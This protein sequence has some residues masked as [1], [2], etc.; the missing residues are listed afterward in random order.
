VG[1]VRSLARKVDA[2]AVPP[3]DLPARGELS[4]PRAGV[5]ETSLAWVVPLLAVL[6]VLC[7]GAGMGWSF[8]APPLDSAEQLVWSY[9]LELGY[10]KHPPLPSWIMHGLVA[11]FGPSVPLPFFAAHACTAIALLLAWRLGCEFMSPL[12]SLCAAA[13]TALVGCHGWAN[14]EFNHNSVLLPFQAATLLCFWFAVTRERWSLWWW[15]LAGVFAGLALLVK[16]VALL[17]L[18]A[19]GLYFLTQRRLHV[20]RHILGALLA[21]GTAMAV[22]A[23]HL[24][25]LAS[26]QYMPLLYARRVT[27]HASDFVAWLRAM[28][29]FLLAQAG[30]LSFFMLSAVS[31]WKFRLPPSDPAI[32][33]RP[34]EARRFVW[35]SGAVPAALLLGYAALTGAV[36]EPRWGS[37]LYLLSG[38]LL[39]DLL[40]PSEA[41]TRRVLR[42]A[43]MVQ[44]G[45]W[46]AV[47]LAV[48]VLASALHWQS[49]PQFPGDEL[50]RLATGT[51]SRATDA[52]LRLVV[53]DVWLGGTLVAYSGRPLAV[54]IDG[55]FDRAAWVAPR[56]LLDCGALVL[57]DRSVPR[58]QWRAQV[59]RAIE[60]A[61][62]RGEWL[63]PWS[64][65]RGLRHRDASP[66]R[67]IAW[68][69]L[70][71]KDAANCR[72]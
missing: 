25:W 65:S 55:E 31:L 71:P 44:A 7:W 6:F 36:L 50:A 30:Q 46:A 70:P 61:P 22:V 19:M 57:Q 37:N 53:S 49:R 5:A 9:A 1:N 23:P 67:R 59:T 39:L 34:V 26:H 43:A 17:P 58:V 8:R 52:R 62:L 56:D 41:G 33:R 16:Y 11:V 32:V 24:A 45:L 48:P 4:S 54:L 66:R 72:L 38:W 29:I 14:Y 2:A 28:G 47:A 27:L 21:C 40:A 51:W 12:R 60:G 18:G 13:L 20:G 64:P 3:R 10:W 69:V 42:T 35:I 63:L 15:T 68:A